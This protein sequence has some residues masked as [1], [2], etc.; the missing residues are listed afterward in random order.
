MVKCGFPPPPPQK[1]IL[2]DCWGFN[3]DTYYKNL[4]IIYKQ[5]FQRPSETD[6]D[7]KKP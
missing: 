2:I 4:F 5:D 7:S 1:A 3:P 6:F